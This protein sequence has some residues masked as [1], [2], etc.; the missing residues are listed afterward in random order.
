MKNRYRIVRD[1]YAGYEAQIKYW[2][3]PIVWFQLHSRGDFCNT[4]LSVEKAEALINKHRNCK[5][6]VKYID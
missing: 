5:K 1:N 4:N 2:Y 6:V 3:F